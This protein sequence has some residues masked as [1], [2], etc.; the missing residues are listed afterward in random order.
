[1]LYRIL[2][3]LL[4]FITFIWCTSKE[5][6]PA[7]ENTIDIQDIYM[8]EQD[9]DCIIVDVNSYW[10]WS[11]TLLPINKN[12]I[13]KLDII[14]SILPKWDNHCTNVKVQIITEDHIPTCYNNTCQATYKN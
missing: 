13:D 9:T 12:F 6:A 3:I 2:I 5:P 4:C 10:C 8:C 14:N 7:S 11:N 1:M